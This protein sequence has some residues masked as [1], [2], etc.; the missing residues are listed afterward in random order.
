MLGVGRL[1]WFARDVPEADL[2]KGM[3]IALL[4]GTAGG[5]MGPVVGDLRRSE[6]KLVARHSC[7]CHFG[8]GACIF[9]VSKAETTYP[10]IIPQPMMPGG[11]EHGRAF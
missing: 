3:A 9:T 2:Q 1:L 4:N 11:G 5:L 10:G 6:R 8:T 7:L